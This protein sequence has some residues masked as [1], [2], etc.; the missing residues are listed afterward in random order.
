MVISNYLFINQV[1]RASRKYIL[2]QGP[3]P[4]TVG[5][6]WL[7]VWQRNSK[8]ILML[9]R[10][11][12]RGQQKC[13]QYWPLHEGQTMDFPNVNLSLEHVESEPGQHYTVRTLK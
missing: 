11:I 1:S 13:H 6:F 7:T 10:V 4:S 3:L 5:H 12:E 2:A 8:A 9:N